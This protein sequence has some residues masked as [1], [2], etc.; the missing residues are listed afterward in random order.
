MW[1]PDS[2]SFSHIASKAKKFKFCVTYELRKVPRFMIQS[3]LLTHYYWARVAITESRNPAPT[4]VRQLSRKSEG[5]KKVCSKLR[6]LFM[7]E[8]QRYFMELLEK[9][10]HFP[11]TETLF[12]AICFGSASSPLSLS[13]SLRVS[14]F[15]YL[16]VSALSLPLS[17]PLSLFSANS[18]YALFLLIYAHSPSLSSSCSWADF[19]VKCLFLSPTPNFKVFKTFTVGQQ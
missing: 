1:L 7:S 17:L 10:T 9:Q 2:M 19:R 11:R 4:A 6:A 18:L 5:N 3:S 16:A 14:H 8:Y 15:L 13:L 12:V